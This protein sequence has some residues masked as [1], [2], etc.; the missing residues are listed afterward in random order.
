MRKKIVLQRSIWIGL[1]LIWMCFIFC[2]SLQPSEVS[3]EESA[4]VLSLAQKI[5]PFMTM[6]VIRKMAHFVEFAFLGV[7]LFFTFRSFGRK[8]VL[9]A[10]GTGLAV[11]S[12]DEILQL[13]SEGRSGQV[14][15]VFLDFSGVLFGIVLCWFLVFHLLPSGK[16]KDPRLNGQE[17]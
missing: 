4:S 16:G 10:L 9:P 13:S 12:A 15:D 14:S 3:S 8:I 2:R 6:F 11:S 7:L 17:K 1:D 5:L